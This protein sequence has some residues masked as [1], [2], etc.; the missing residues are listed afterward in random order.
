VL[1]LF[2]EVLHVYDSQGQL[3]F[4]TRM[5]AFRLRE[6]VRLYTGEDQ[7]EEVLR[8]QARKIL[9]FATA[10]D[11]IDSSDSRKVGALKRKGLRSL[12]RDRW[13]LMDPE[14]RELGTI[15]EDRMSLAVA[16]RILN[17]IPATLA[18]LTPLT[19]LPFWP[20][21]I[22]QTY[23]AVVEGRPV[24]TFRQNFNPIVTKI[25]LEFLPAAE[26]LLDRRVGI[27]AGVLLCVMEGRQG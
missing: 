1:K 8:I 24:C 10:Y 14:D 18:A 3:A 2:G 6:D 9:D 26:E 7:R 12:L 25:S 21:L 5:K 27:A 11:V 23:T 22:P 13:I 16:R 20:N 19:E 17:V 15:E 4:Y